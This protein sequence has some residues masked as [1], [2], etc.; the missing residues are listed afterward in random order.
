MANL[1]ELER[2]EAAKPPRTVLPSVKSSVW[3]DTALS[4][5]AYIDG[6]GEFQHTLQAQRTLMREQENRQVSYL[7]LTKDGK[8]IRIE[9]FE[10][11]TRGHLA[12][13]DPMDAWMQGI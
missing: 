7:E 9:V 2:A 5:A 13:D 12:P 1:D 10:V 4:I 8:T 3:T 6:D 11:E